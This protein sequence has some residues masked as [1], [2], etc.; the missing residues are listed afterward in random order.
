MLCQL[1]HIEVMK[2]HRDNKQAL[3]T[4][5]NSRINL[6]MISTLIYQNL[7]FLNRV[8]IIKTKV[9]L[10][11]AYVTIADFDHPVLTP[12]GFYLLLKTFK[13]F[14]FQIFWL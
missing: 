11:Q 14:G 13:S 6:I 5:I 8:I 7:Q 12:W 4:K 10:P 1:S 3:V 9:L 2:F